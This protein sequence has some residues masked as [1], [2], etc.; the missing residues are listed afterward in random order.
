MPFEEGDDVE[1]YGGEEE[2]EEGFSMPYE[3]QD[4]PEPGPAR[5]RQRVAGRGSRKIE[6]SVSRAGPDADGDFV[7]SVFDGMD[8][9]V[10]SQAS[11]I[12]SSLAAVLET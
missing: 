10:S 9:P 3:D 6:V 1:A 5:A 12:P 8:A 11:A 7:G 4:N 2:F